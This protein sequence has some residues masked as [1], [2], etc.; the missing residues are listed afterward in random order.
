MTLIT[1]QAGKAVMKDGKVGT[2]QACCCDDGDGVGCEDCTLACCL[3]IEGRDTCDGG[4]ELISV[5][6]LI[7][8]NWGREINAGGQVSATY[9]FLS[10]ERDLEVEVIY[11]CENGVI[12]MI[13]EVG[14]KIPGGNVPYTS[15]R[16]WAT[17]RATLGLDGC[18]TGIEFGELT[19]S[20][21]PD[22]V[23]PTMEWVCT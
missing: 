12:D 20:D 19:E 13:I 18:P 4:T 9:V 1:F 11:E 17:A 14:E 2:E 7:V 8:E 15:F 3:S 22:F 5:D 21:G 23:L 10:D 16:Q 6:P